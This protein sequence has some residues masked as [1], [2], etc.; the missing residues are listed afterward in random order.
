MELLRDSVQQILIVL[1]CIVHLASPLLWGAARDTNC[2]SKIQWALLV[3]YI[4]K[5]TDV[6][7]LCTRTI[8]SVSPITVYCA[9][10][11]RFGLAT[12]LTHCITITSAV[13]PVN[14]RDV[15]SYPSTLKIKHR[16]ELQQRY[17]QGRWSFSLCIAMPEDR[18]A[19]VRSNF[20]IYISPLQ[21]MGLF[22]TSVD[23]K[24]IRTKA[25]SQN[26]QPGQC[27]DVIVMWHQN[28]SLNAIET[29]LCSLYTL[30]L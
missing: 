10:R 23:I 20:G 30:I 11:C 16:F 24:N 3:I 25:T 7:T 21:S 19:T 15:C 1:L 14:P 22:R 9:L 8:M 12:S 13:E 27:S 6:Q 17:S 2:S 4:R 28:D 18:E 29:L 26:I 5:T